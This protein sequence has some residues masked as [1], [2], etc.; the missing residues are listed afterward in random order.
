MNWVKLRMG[1]FFR[2]ILLTQ[3]SR[4]TICNNEGKTYTI[5]M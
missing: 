4:P 5:Q 2:D 3:P 1:K